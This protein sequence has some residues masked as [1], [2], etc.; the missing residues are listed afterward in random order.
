MAKK[1]KE[2]TSVMTAREDLPETMRYEE[3]LNG[4]RLALDNGC[5]EQAWQHYYNLYCI[6]PNKDLPLNNYRGKGALGLCKVLQSIP[7]DHEIVTNLMETDPDLLRR[8][9]QKTITNSF[10]RRFVGRKYLFY[11]ADECE[12]YPAMFE[13]A[14]NCL[15]KGPKNSFIF[16]YNDRDAQTGVQWANKLIQSKD[17]KQR[18]CGYIVKAIYYF[19]RYTKNGKSPEE[20]KDF[21]NHVLLAKDFNGLENEYT[22]YFYGHMIT[23]PNFARFEN[24]RHYNVRYGYELLNKYLEKGTDPDLIA[25]A[26]RIIAA[27]DTKY[28]SKLK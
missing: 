10:A 25:S 26:K 18:A 2:L 24:G 3:E 28:K 9:S 16:E 22:L 5:Y 6:E 23:D 19:A 27:L 7:A 15:G 13:Y 4:A 17:K 20:G 12:Y 11:A 1:I 14:L 8:K 21:C